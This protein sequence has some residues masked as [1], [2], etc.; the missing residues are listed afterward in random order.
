MVLNAAFALYICE[1][2]DSICDGVKKAEKLLDSGL[3]LQKLE[4]MKGFGK[5]DF[6]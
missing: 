3:A 5:N 6:E 2:V 4:V 1:N